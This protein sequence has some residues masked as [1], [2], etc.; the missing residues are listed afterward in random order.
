MK[1]YGRPGWKKE[2]VFVATHFDS[3]LP[4]NGR[5]LENLLECHCADPEDPSLRYD[6]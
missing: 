3:K 4:K 2:S 5:G 1:K 6:C